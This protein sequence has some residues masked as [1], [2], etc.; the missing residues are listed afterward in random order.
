MNIIVMG[1]QGCGKTTQ[2]DLLS[3]YLKT[4]HISTGEIYRQI[5]QQN[6]PLGRKVKKLLD[7]GQLID[8]ETTYQVI[9]QHLGKIK[10]GFV[11][12]GF[13]RTLIQAQREPFV[14]D[15]V[16]SIN[17]SD[18]ECIQRLLLRN[19][20]DDTKSLIEERLKLFHQETE[21]I[22]NFYRQKG[23][24]IEIDGT[25]SIENV[26]KQILKELDLHG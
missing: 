8:D 24:L 9:D 23:K 5:S 4:P 11:V 14:I 20:F 6:T 18:Q 3:K 7:I 25:G 12:D 10:G 26:H 21:P 15:R 19:R 1:Q 22:L 13:P 2:A 16:I 17:L